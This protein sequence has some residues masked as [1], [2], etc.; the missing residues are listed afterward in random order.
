MVGYNYLTLHTWL[1]RGTAP[2]RDTY[3][4]YYIE[5]K[6]T[7]TV[8]GW[9]KIARVRE[10]GEW[11]LGPCGDHFLVYPELPR[12]SF[13]PLFISCMYHDTKVFRSREDQQGSF[14]YFLDGSDLRSYV[15]LYVLYNT[16]QNSEDHP[17]SNNNM[18]PSQ[19]RFKSH[20]VCFGLIR[21]VLATLGQS[22]PHTRAREKTLRQHTHRFFF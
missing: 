14:S 10:P 12:T 2:K 20:T 11:N 17:N 3:L 19:S 8:G 13:H 6:A 22:T 18:L 9:Y 5:K 7:W 15:I 16:C 4:P 1:R 21:S